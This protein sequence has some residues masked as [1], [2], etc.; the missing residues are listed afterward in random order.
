MVDGFL[1]FV[2]DFKPE[3][4]AAEMAVFNRDLGYA[5]TLDMI[6]RLTG[7][8]IGNGER[9]V[10]APGQ[11]LD[12]CVDAKTG[13]YPD[14]TYRE[15][16]AAYRRARE[17]AL[18]LGEVA[19]MPPTAAGAVLHLRPEFERGYRLMLVS[20]ENDA[21]AWNTFR[22]ALDVFTD[23]DESRAKPGKVV[24]ALR[25]DG[26]MP[27]PRLADLDGEGYDRAPG[28]LT[29]AGVR[30]LEQ[31]AAMTPGDCLKTK[32]IGPKTIPHIRRM[33]A[34]HGLALRGEALDTK[35]A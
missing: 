22:R 17:C 3:F 20:R 25:P 7:Y 16:I 29:R 32:G 26:T 27:S 14:V 1:N 23:R 19:P 18:P 4:L 30:D 31:L 9:F 6:I 15:Q 33:L 28:A 24:Y 34:D 5:G 12:L 2:E 21:R 8:G 11:V 13:R 10:A 35:V